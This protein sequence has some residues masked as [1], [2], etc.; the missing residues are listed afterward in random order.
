[1]NENSIQ[2]GLDGLHGESP[3]SEDDECNF[4]LEVHPQSDV[5][6]SRGLEAEAFPPDKTT[7]ISNLECISSPDVHF[8]LH[9]EAPNPDSFKFDRDPVGE[10]S[11]DNTTNTPRLYL[12]NTLNLPSPSIDNNRTPNLWPLQNDDEATLLQHF[13]TNLCIWVLNPSLPLL[14]PK[15]TPINHS[16]TTAIETATSSTLSSH[17]H[18][19]SPPSF[20]PSSPSQPNTQVSTGNSLL[21]PL[22]NTNVSVYLD[23]FP[24]YHHHQAQAPNPKVLALASY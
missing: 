18:P 22:M 9:S 15:L 10:V 13:T 5:L 7:N 14:I 21:M 23:S 3:S 2:E 4:S 17:Q 6:S 1:V 11:N 20:P 8:G 16:S 12:N 24:L 19:K